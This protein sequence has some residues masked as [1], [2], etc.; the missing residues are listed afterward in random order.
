M[1]L[2]NTCSI[3]QWVH[4]FWPEPWA[5]WVF[6]VLK[7]LAEYNGHTCSLWKMDSHSVSPVHTERE[8]VDLR[9]VWIRRTGRADTHQG[10]RHIWKQV[11]HLWCPAALPEGEPIQDMIIT[12]DQVM[13]TTGGSLICS[14]NCLMFLKQLRLAKESNQVMVSLSFDKFNPS[15]HHVWDQRTG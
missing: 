4:L 15:G 7:A 5:W 11:L 10:D 14:F 13:L 1:K 2:Q 3:K 6:T 12:A 8:A 9:Q